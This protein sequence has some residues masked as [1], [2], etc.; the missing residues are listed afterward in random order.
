MAR[1][2]TFTFSWALVNGLAGWSGLWKGHDKKIGDEKIW[3]MVYGQ[4][5]LTG[6]KTQPYLC[7]M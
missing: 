6:Q 3:E 1:R 5:V 4:A 7:L 2:V